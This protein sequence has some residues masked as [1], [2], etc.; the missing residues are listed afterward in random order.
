MCRVSVFVGGPRDGL[1]V[2]ERDG[3][4]LISTEFLS[5]VVK[6]CQIL[7]SSILPKQPEAYCLLRTESGQ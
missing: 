6:R 5:V 3:W 4:S 2:E 1:D 7:V